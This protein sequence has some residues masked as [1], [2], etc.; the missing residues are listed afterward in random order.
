MRLLQVWREARGKRLENELNDLLAHVDG[1]SALAKSVCFNNI[2]ATHE[3]LVAA[4]DSL[5]VPDRK[6]LIRSLRK[7]ASKMW[8]Q[9]RRPPLPWDSGLSCSTSKADT[10]PVKAQRLCCN[11]PMRLSWLHPSSVPFETLTS[12][13]ASRNTRAGKACQTI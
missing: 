4:Y 5:P 2:W 8:K 9:G 12:S 6:L 10:R 1:M 13:P 11:E 3:Y 7:G